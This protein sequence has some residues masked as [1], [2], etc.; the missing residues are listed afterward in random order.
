MF[1]IKKITMIYDM[2]KS[3]KIYALAGF[4]LT[5]PDKGLVGIIGPSGSGKSTLM[6]CLSTLKNPTDGQIIYNGIEFSSLKNSQRENLRR[7]EFGFVFQRHFLV[8]YMSVVD[9]VAVAGVSKGKTTIDRAKSLLSGFGI[10]EKEFKKRPSKLSGGQ[11]QRTAIARA[12]I[13]KPK[14]LFAD[15]PTAALDHE[16]AFSVMDILK[17]YSKENLVL[18]ITHDHSILK[19]ADSVIEM[20]DGNISAI[21]G[22]EDI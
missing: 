20:W 17:D 9:N 10:G 18:V 16:N 1:D 8:P 7:N 6:Y 5:L 4:D 12:M 2:D 22:G 15:E 13:N 14:V 21:R 19:G 3:E 11:R